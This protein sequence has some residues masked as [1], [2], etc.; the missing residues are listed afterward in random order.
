MRSKARVGVLF[1]GRSGEHEVSL[2]SA[3]SVIAALD[4]ARYEMVPLGITRSGRWVTAG[5]ALDL[6]AAAVGSGRPAAEVE[7]A[8]LA[9]SSPYPDLEL[10]ASCDVIFPVLHGPYGEDGTIQGLLELIGVPYVGCGVTG[11][12]VGM[13]KGLMK[14]AFAAYD[15]PQVRYRLVTRAQWQAAPAQVIRE[16]EEALPYPMFVKPANL[17]SSVGVS[18]ARDGEELW[19]GLDEA[20]RYDRRLIVEEGIDRAREIECSVLGNDDPATSVPGEV[21]PGNEFYDYA[22]KYLD[23]TSRLLIPAP[24]TE[25]QT[26]QVQALAAAAFRAIDGA[27][28]SRVDFLLSPE[29]G[30]LY[31]NEINTLPGFTD[32]SMYPKLWEASGLAYPTLIDRLIELAWERHGR[33]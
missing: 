13:D 9:D 26:R 14:A 4:P 18:K 24:L 5:R 16:L 2:A 19:A 21:V 8:V 32:I 30:R 10:L 27:G 3:R 1:G 25:A 28:L 17:G 11:S 29:D 6:L 20:A 23:G 15:L 33:R 31:V 7:A 12:A 22:A